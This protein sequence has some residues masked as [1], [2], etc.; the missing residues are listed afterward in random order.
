[1]KRIGVGKTNWPWEE[2]PALDYTGLR[3]EVL[4]SQEVDEIDVRSAHGKP[5]RLGLRDNFAALENLETAFEG[6]QCGEV[7]SAEPFYRAARSYPDGNRKT[8][9][10]QIPFPDRSR[11]SLVNPPTYRV[12]HKCNLAI[13]SC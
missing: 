6:F 9:P 10:K 13:L 7:G 12:N 2:Y 4:R 1:M 5:H 11:F 8:R 3:N